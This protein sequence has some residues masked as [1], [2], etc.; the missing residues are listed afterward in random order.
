MT[1]HLRNQRRLGRFVTALTPFLVT[2]GLVAALHLAIS[3]PTAAQ[4]ERKLRV[5]LQLPI[6]NHLGRNLTAFKEIVEKQ[7]EGRI[8]I[9]I[10]DKAQLYR[11]NEVIDAVRNGKIE[12]GTVALNQFRAHVP[13]VD[14]FGQPF[15]FNLAPILKVATSPSND[16]RKRLDEAIVKK[17]GT[18]PLWWQPYGTTVFFSRGSEGIRQPQRIKGRKVRVISAAE[19]EFIGLCTGLPNRIPGSKQFAAL[20]NGTVELGITGVSG[21]RSRNLWQVTDTITKTNHSAIEFVV[22]INQAVWSSLGERDRDIISKAAV[23]VERQLRDG[24]ADIETASYAFAREKNM[25]I[26]EVAPN[27]LLEWRACSARMLDQFLARSGEL[28]QRLMADY[29][30]LRLDPCCSSGP[31]GRFTRH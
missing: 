13:A 18:V 14:I 20:E 9:E 17:T 30:R 6:T 10:F 19:G 16:I 31:P 23:S 15:M 7:T 12:M 1:S 25:T 11:D 28:G 5:T 27:D 26:V 2:L 24:Y 22:I 21:V 4:P 3:S 8:S 29:G